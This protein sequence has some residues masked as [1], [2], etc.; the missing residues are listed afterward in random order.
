MITRSSIAFEDFLGSSI[1]PQVMPP[2]HQTEWGIITLLNNFPWILAMIL[3]FSWLRPSVCL[4]VVKKLSQEKERPNH[5]KGLFFIE[6]ITCV[7]EGYEFLSTGKW[8]AGG[9]WGTSLKLIGAKLGQRRFVWIHQPLKWQ[10]SGELCLRGEIDLSFWT[11]LGPH[12]IYTLKKQSL[13][14]TGR[15]Y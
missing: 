13:M 10:L 4:M 3:T 5:L 9:K 7:W 8:P 12:R 1:A 2:C 15:S 14:E 11:S 6:H